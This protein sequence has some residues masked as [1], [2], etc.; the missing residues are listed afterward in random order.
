MNSVCVPLTSQIHFEISD[1]N[2]NTSLWEKQRL[3]VLYSPLICMLMLFCLEIQTNMNNDPV[4]MMCEVSASEASNNQCS[5]LLLFWKYIQKT[6]SLSLICCMIICD[7][8][9]VSLI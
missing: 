6:K 9:N 2:L 8:S 1:S 4:E 3:K 7:A 5:G